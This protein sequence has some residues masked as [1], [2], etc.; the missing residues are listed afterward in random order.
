MFMADTR[1]RA[2]AESTFDRNQRREAQISE[3]LKQ[4]AA[5]HDAAVK[6]MHRL[7]TLRLARDAKSDKNNSRSSD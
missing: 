1:E 3:A 6:N 5:R 4:E 2:A 7:R